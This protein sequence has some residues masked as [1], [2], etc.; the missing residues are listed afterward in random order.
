LHGCSHRPIDALL[1]A[2]S[3]STCKQSELEKGDHYLSIM[4]KQE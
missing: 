2:N 4:L 3:N 1:Q